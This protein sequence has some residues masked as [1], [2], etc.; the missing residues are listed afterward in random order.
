M[1]LLDKLLGHDSKWYVERSAKAVLDEDMGEAMSCLK[2][3]EEL[4]PDDEMKKKVA[5]ERAKVTH[6]IYAHALENA[7][8]FMR[9]HNHEAAQNALDLAA[10]HVQ[11]DAERDALNALVEGRFEEEDVGQVHVEGEDQVSTLDVEDKWNLY[12]TKLSFEKAQHYDEL[13]N[14]FK[15]AWIDLQEGKFDEAIEGLGAVYR[16]HGED[17]V[18]MTELARAYFG[19]GSFDKAD[20]LLVKAD[21]IRSDIETKL[22]RVEVL[23][24]MKR[25]DVAEEVLQA[26][27]DMDP[28][29][30]TVLARIAQHGLLARDFESGLAAI[31]VL[32]EALPQDISVQR[33][34]GRLYLES[35]NDAKAL[36]CY[37]T[38]NR[39]YWQVNPQTKK[40]TFDQGS[41]AAA[42]ALYVKLGEN[43]GR[44]VELLDAIRANTTG[45]EH[46]GV[47]LQ[48]ADVY[49][50]M[51]KKSKSAEMLTESMRFMDDMLDRAKGGERAM[52]MLQ[53][54]EVAER[55]G[56][57]E[58]SASM[59]EGARSIFES[60]ASTGHPV[61]AFYLDMID[62]KKAGEPFP[63]GQELQARMVEFVR[64]RAAA[65]RPAA[66]M[67][68]SM[69][70]VSVAVAGAGM[71]GSEDAMRKMAALAAQFQTTLPEADDEADDHDEAAESD[72][73]AST[74]ET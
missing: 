59:L 29:N 13:G 49:E 55:V 51:N 64:S 17:A 73:G 31:E 27:H 24:S 58:K 25:F 9:A 30:N 10:R 34:A 15:K 39:L 74:D 5:E 65:E 56:E 70:G 12:V 60:D 46:V 22:L 35:G 23:W 48:L 42:A 50:K 18:V 1:G 43:L 67:V 14:A 53:Y 16:D 3:A 54:A 71:E 8:R 11:N 2:R 20:E 69:P 36:E 40:I 41:A 72:D 61:A 32:L 47:C 33:L 52:V 28:E 4:A 38:V 6:L 19:K 68:S 21:K 57:S 7:E 45:E 66:S 26:A 44:A 62:R 37:E 63:T